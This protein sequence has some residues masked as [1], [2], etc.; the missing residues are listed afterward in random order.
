VREHAVEELVILNEGDVL[1]FDVFS[2]RTFPSTMEKLR[3]AENDVN[4]QLIHEGWCSLGEYYRLI[5]LPATAYSEE[6]GWNSDK[7]MEVSYTSCL[8]KSGRPALAVNFHV[9]PT[10]GFDSFH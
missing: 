4:Y 2:D 1:C 10:R 6:V 3:A 5:G 9:E 7:K 8:T